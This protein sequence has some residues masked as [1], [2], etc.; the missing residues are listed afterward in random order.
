MV[1]DAAEGGC[2]V[3]PSGGDRGLILVLLAAGVVIRSRRRGRPEGGG[4]S[5]SSS[6]RR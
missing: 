2:T 1:K 3:A 5:R 6:P 4:R